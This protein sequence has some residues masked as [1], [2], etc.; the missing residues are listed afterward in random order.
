MAITEQDVIE[1]IQAYNEKTEN[2]YKGNGKGKGKGRGEGK[3]NKKN[4]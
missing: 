3:E 2:S 1:K 4:S